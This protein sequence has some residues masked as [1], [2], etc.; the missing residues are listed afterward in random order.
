[1][2]WSTRL[3]SWTRNF[4]SSPIP[5]DGVHVDFLLRMCLC[6]GDINSSAPLRLLLLVDRDDLI[7]GILLPIEYIKPADSLFPS[8]GVT[9][10]FFSLLLIHDA[11]VGSCLMRKVLAW[12]FFV[13]DFV[14]RC[15]N[16]LI[17]DVDKFSTSPPSERF[18]HLAVREDR[19]S[20]A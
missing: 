14:P 13:A 11:D 17:Y 4:F 20:P 18:C 2:S 5:S 15:F 9:Q 1:M 6:R 10:N 16:A 8:A 7:S 19:K 12:S 3:I